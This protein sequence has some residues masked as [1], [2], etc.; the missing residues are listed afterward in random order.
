[1]YNYK[2]VKNIFAYCIFLNEYIIIYLL[3][4]FQSYIMY[5]YYLNIVYCQTF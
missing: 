1:M 2:S 3:I 5:D 4:I